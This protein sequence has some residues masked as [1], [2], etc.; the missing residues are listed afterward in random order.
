MKSLLPDMLRRFDTQRSVMAAAKSCV[1][2]IAQ[3]V[4]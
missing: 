2:A 1:W 3:F 4:M